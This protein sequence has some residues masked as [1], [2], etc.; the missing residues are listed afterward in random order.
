MTSWNNSNATEY[1]NELINEI[2][3]IRKT[4]RKSKEH[5]R[6]LSNV[7]VF[8]E[9]VFGKKSLFY[10]GISQLSWS[11][12]GNMLITDPHNYDYEVSQKHNSACLKDL[13]QANGI[14]LSAQDQLKRKNIRDVFV[15]TGEQTNE[16]IKL[17]K[18]AEHKL[19]KVIREIPKSEKEIQDKFEDVLIGSE[20]QYF[21]EYPHIEYSSKQYIPDFSF[22]E[23][24]LAI[25]IK[26]CKESERKLIAQINDDI[27]AYK[28]KFNN[29]IFVIYDLGN[30]RDVETFKES[31]EKQEN[32]FIQIVKH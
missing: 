5:L 11:N 6:W 24:N 9:D 10:Q 3:Q 31:F 32:V 26:L 16:L 19:R 25:E 18:I 20:I 27:L 14:L 28:T 2:P 30:I 29:L 7:L 8:L 15:E 22:I 1:L 4:G 12:T 17:L 13:E 23:Q 21:R